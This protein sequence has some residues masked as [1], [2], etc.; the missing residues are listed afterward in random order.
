MQT[1]VLIAENDRNRPFKSGGE[2][3]KSVNR[4]IVKEELERLNFATA[5]LKGGGDWQVI[6][7]NEP[8]QLMLE[9]SEGQKIVPDLNDPLS[10]MSK[11]N[12]AVS[13]QLRTS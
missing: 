6:P 5:H 4:H 12:D 11:F 13:R 3:W 2:V 1:Y 9:L 8:M 10:W 7:V